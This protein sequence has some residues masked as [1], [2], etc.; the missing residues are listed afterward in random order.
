MSPQAPLPLISFAE[1]VRATD[2]HA[3]HHLPLLE[4]AARLLAGED[5]APPV[6]RRALAA[7]LEQWRYR[8]LGRHGGRLS[9]EDRQFVDALDLAANELAQRGS[10]PPRATRQAVHDASAVD[11]AV[12]EARRGVEPAVSL[13][14][15]TARAAG[16]TQEHF[17][18]TQPDN[19]REQVGPAS[20]RSQQAPLPPDGRDDRPVPDGRDARPTI[21]RRR[22]LLYAP[23]YLSNYC[24]NY[25]LYCGF[26]HPHAIE[27][28]H[29]G[30]EE[31]LREADVL[32]ARG[33]RHV[34]LVAGDFPSL[35]TPRYHA[36]VLGALRARG[37]APAV[38]IAPQ[39]T[40]AYAA[41]AVAG[42]I[43]VTLYQ[44]TYD[45]RLYAQYHPRGSKAAYDWRLEALDRAAE[46]GMKRLGLGILLGL[47]DPR[48]DLAA[49][50]R[51]GR[52][53][54]ARFPDRTLAFSLPRIY[55]A[56]DGFRMRFPVDDELFVRMYC[57]LRIAFPRAELVLS[58]REPEA[59]R[60]RLATICI[61]QMSAGSCTAPGG[62]EDAASGRRAGEQFPVC[63]QRSPAEVAA[64]LR[65]AG[66]E[67][68]WEIG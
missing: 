40:E 62:Y 1:R 55:E 42:A 8:Y 25:C 17:V 35:T 60:D 15:V 29:L 56:P 57:A 30:L 11:P 41:L 43:G 32:R 64:W 24:I 4:E 46:A 5:Q 50:I 36:E 33:F 47:G 3:A 59:L 34:L 19:A 52:Y 23:L 67:I 54:A 58:T 9:P 38:E 63:D 37:I 12:L 13:E 28:R 10:R 6:A 26:R 68:A 21:A 2:E 27:R 45:E 65:D 18:G 53:L 14:S 49:L 7:K 51:H 22:M 16:L 20:R 66:F 48:E 61:T 39:T 31:A 44:E